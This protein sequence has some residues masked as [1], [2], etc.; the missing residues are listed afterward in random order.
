L[1]FSFHR[2]GLSLDFAGTVGGRTSEQPE[3]RLPDP[4]AFSA[5]LAEAGLVEGASPT[6]AELGRARALREA[7]ARAAAAVT[8]GDSP[9]RADLS[10]INTAAL[11]LRRGPHRRRGQLAGRAGNGQHSR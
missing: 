1:R 11:G 9:S 10:V 6:A 5:W 7:I 8:A 2:G 4:E 3:E